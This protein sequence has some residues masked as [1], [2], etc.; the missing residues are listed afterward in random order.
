MLAFKATLIVRY[1]TITGLKLEVWIFL[2]VYHARVCWLHYTGVFNDARSDVI[3]T[4][5]NMYMTSSVEDDVTNDV[6]RML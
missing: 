5:Y 2:R 4:Y 3:A 6:T 1:V